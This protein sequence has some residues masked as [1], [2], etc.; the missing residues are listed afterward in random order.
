[1]IT[2]M[3][4]L[5]YSRHP[6]ALQAFLS[7]VLELPSV[8]AGEGWPIYA[9]PPTELAVHPTEGK[10]EHE[11]FLI[12]DDIEKTVAKITEHGIKSTPIEDRGWGLVTTLELAAGESIGL[13]EP[14]HPRPP[15][16]T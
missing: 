5:I 9:V 13:Y 2:G 14:H 7:N 8:D 16:K 4:A 15:H 1:M 12:C 3:H 11:L 10:P 6:K